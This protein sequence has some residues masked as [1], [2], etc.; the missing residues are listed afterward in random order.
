MGDSRLCAYMHC[1]RTARVVTCRSQ[2]IFRPTPKYMNYKADVAINLKSVNPN[3]KKLSLA[4]GYFYSC[5]NYESSQI[6]IFNF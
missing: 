5:I 3:K 2:T 6:L 4:Y 1:L